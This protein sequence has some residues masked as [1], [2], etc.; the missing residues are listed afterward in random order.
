M[1]QGASRAFTEAF[2][3]AVAKSG[4]NLT[5]LGVAL[6]CTRQNVRELQRGRIPGPNVASRLAEA[7]DQPELLRL[8]IKARGIHCA[9]CGQPATAL[10]SRRRYCSDAC[11]RIG[12]TLG[13]R[14]PSEVEMAILEELNGARSAIDAFCRSCEPEGVCRQ[15]ECPLRMM[16]PLPL[17]TARARPVPPRN[18]GWTPGRRKRASEVMVAE[19][20]ENGTH[21]R[22]AITRG[23]RAKRAVA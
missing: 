3:T 16:S 17:V 19:W 1:N 21:R 18:H 23:I 5:Q 6:G 9:V 22:A 12:Y 15:A 20:R 4:L 7:L 8:A 11:W 13:R 10:T 2:T 14:A